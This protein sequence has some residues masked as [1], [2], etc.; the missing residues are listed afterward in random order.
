MKY[1]SAAVLASLFVASSASYAATANNDAVNVPAEF[2]AGASSTLSATWAPASSVPTGQIPN[3]TTKVGTLTVSGADSHAGFVVTSTKG[4]T[5]NGLAY[6]TFTGENGSGLVTHFA[7]DAGKVTSGSEGD[8]WVWTSNGA[9]SS[10][11]LYVGKGET[12]KATK[13]TTTLTVR[14]FD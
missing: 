4:V 8:T 2:T 1:I 7:Q 10:Q 3:D 9:S 13:Y 12:V 5:I 11:D 14:T 6:V